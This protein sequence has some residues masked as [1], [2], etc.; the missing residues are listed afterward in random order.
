M[1]SFL[2]L[3]RSLQV[4]GRKFGYSGIES[5]LGRNKKEKLIF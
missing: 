3:D 4:G 1:P 2:F 5:T